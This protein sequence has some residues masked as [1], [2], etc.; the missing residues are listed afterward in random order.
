ML[1]I[2]EKPIRFPTHTALAVSTDVWETI[3]I[4]KL[5]E[6]MFRLALFRPFSMEP[7]PNDKKNYPNC[8]WY[9]MAVFNTYEMCEELFKI[10]VEAMKR[11]DKVFDV[12]EHLE[13][14]KLKNDESP[15]V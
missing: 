6:D 13:T 3:V 8:K 10:I 7:D 5:R 12:S 9:P 15:P 14:L 4:R 11:G 1:I 2:L